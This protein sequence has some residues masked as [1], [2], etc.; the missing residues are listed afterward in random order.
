[1]GI[2]QKLFVLT[3]IALAALAM[4]ACAH[5]S[6]G[7]TS[8]SKKASTKYPCDVFSST[9]CFRKP[10]GTTVSQRSGPDFEIFQVIDGN[11]TTAAFSMYLGTTPEREAEHATRILSTTRGDVGVTVNSIRNS[12]NINEMDVRISYPTGLNIHVFG[13]ST[14]EERNLLAE[15]LQS[16][17]RC[18]KEQFT[19][20]ACSTEPLF[21]E[22]ILSEIRV[23]S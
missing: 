17:R 16:F 23:G 3:V 5:G 21:D 8:P 10:F 12:S 18:N 9:F 14:K 13:A 19:S 20:I 1:M 15:M 4:S 2:R 6:E 22:E 7:V 11:A